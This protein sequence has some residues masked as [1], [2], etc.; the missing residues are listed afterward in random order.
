MAREFL[1]GGSGAKHARG[2]RAPDHEEDAC[3][4]LC[5]GNLA[6][7]RQ[8]VTQRYRGFVRDWGAVR[9][10]R[11]HGVSRPGARP[12]AGNASLAPVSNAPRTR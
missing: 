5:F 8:A 11:D 3:A 9:R 6:T 4:T 2:P 10:S 1:T 7:G 12:P